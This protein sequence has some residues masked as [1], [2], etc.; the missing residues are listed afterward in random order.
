MSNVLNKETVPEEKIIKVMRWFKI[1]KSFYGKKENTILENNQYH[2][3][4]D[5][6][7]VIEGCNNYYIDYK[8]NL[9]L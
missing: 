3:K 7:K 5:S 6:E 1:F 4:L 2:S 8:R 9:I